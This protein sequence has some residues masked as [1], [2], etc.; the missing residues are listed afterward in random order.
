M[1]Y[2]SLKVVDKVGN[3]WNQLQETIIDWYEILEP[4]YGVQEKAVVGA[5]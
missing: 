5:K 3:N 4:V 1:A 2:I